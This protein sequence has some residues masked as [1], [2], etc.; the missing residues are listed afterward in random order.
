MPCKVRTPIRVLNEPP[1]LR[2]A[3]AWPSSK[4]NQGARAI[5]HLEAAQRA[6]PRDTHPLDWAAATNNLGNAY[7]ISTEGD[8]GANIEQAI[9]HLED[10]LSVYQ[11]SAFPQEYADTNIKLARL[12]EERVEGSLAHNLDQG[13]VCLHRAAQ[14]HTRAT[15]PQQWADI[16]ST[17]GMFYRRR[18][19]GDKRANRERSL[20]ACRGAA[21][22]YEQADEGT[23]RRRELASIY[24]NL[25]D[26]YRQRLQGVPRTNRETAL[27]Y[28]HRALTFLEGQTPLW[29]RTYNLIGMAND[30][31]DDAEHIEDAIVAYE[32]ALTI[33]TR[34]THLR[35]WAWA[36]NNMGRAYQHR[37][38]GTPRDNRLT[39][40]GWYRRVA[41]AEVQT[42][43]A[44]IWAM[45]SLNR[46]LVCSEFAAETL[47][48]GDEAVWTRYEQEAQEAL[49]DALEYAHR[50]QDTD[51]I[52]QCEGAL[53][54]LHAGES[55][56]AA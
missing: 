56:H 25:G 38:T 47:M 40:L 54:H 26:A 33:L 12:Y 2:S 10:S 5:P 6:F 21:A 45:A 42:V 49:D 55:V 35:L 28:F 34:E 31:F 4:Q 53:R 36:G 11:R 20:R 51:L 43:D 22:V 13:I 27:A 30:D 1:R 41:V 9:S 16:Q 8:R 32:T 52:R 18:L 39:A 3:A 15:A 7:R 46:G 50:Q 24:N 23:E 37:R 14:V 17:L 19:R 29:A 44:R 48:Q